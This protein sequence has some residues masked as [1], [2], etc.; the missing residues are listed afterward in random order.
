LALLLARN[1]ALSAAAAYRLLHDTSSPNGSPNGA[2]ALIDACAAVVSLIGQG[3]CSQ[4]A[5]KVQ[6]VAGEGGQAAALR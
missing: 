4:G 5:A 6:K 2:T 1:S 3:S